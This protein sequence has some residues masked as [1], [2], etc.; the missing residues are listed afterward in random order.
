MMEY[1]AYTS[2]LHAP[3]FGHALYNISGSIIIRLVATELPYTQQQAENP[4]EYRVVST[5]AL[6]ALSG[7][8][9]INGCKAET[10][11]NCSPNSYIFVGNGTKYFWTKTFTVSQSHNGNVMFLLK[12]R[13]LD[14]YDFEGPGTVRLQIQLDGQLVGSTGIQQ[15]FYNETCHQRTLSASCLALGLAAGSHTVKGRI[16]VSG[17]PN[18]SASGDL[19]LVFFGN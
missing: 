6:V 3:L 12:T 14:C 2:E 5:S 10:S 17:L 18:L 7:N 4:V 13:I 16:N 15:F 9:P 19:G 11:T 8:I 1:L